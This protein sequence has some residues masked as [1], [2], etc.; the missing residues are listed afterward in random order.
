MLDVEV[1]ANEEKDEP[2]QRPN[3]VDYNWTDEVHKYLKVT[4]ILQSGMDRDEKVP[5]SQNEIWSFPADLVPDTTSPIH[6]RDSIKLDADRDPKAQW[7]IPERQ[8]PHRPLR[9][10]E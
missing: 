8:A 2:P 5:L 7:R 6:N 9:R 3:V 10:Q 1:G 4:K